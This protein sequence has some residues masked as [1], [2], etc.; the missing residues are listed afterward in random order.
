MVRSLCP[1]PVRV[2]GSDHKRPYGARVGSPAMPGVDSQVEPTPKP[3]RG[4]RR[5]RQWAPV[6]SVVCL[7]LLVL[8][9]A[10]GAGYVIHESSIRTIAVISLTSFQT[11]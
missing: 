6:V 9:A 8:G 5:R 4:P 3:A 2:A 10:A 1:G 7:V 11:F